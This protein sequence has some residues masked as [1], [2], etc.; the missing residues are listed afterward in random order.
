MVPGAGGEPARYLTDQGILSTTLP[1]KARGNCTISTGFRMSP[2][3]RGR[4]RQAESDRDIYV[5]ITVDDSRLGEH[6]QW[7]LGK[8]RSSASRAGADPTR[9]HSGSNRV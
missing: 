2:A 3:S 9:G 4:P 8:A 5:F 1:S 6:P 7:V